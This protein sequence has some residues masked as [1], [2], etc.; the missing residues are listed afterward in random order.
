MDAVW[1]IFGCGFFAVASFF[2]GR[3]LMHPLG[4]IFLKNT[5]AKHP[6]LGI[7]CIF[8]KNGRSRWVDLDFSKE[9][10]DN[11]NNH[12]EVDASMSYRVSPYNVP[13][14]TYMEGLP[15]PIELH[16]VLGTLIDLNKMPPSLDAKRVESHILRVR[17]L[18]RAKLWKE[19]FQ[20]I[21]YTLYATVGT[22]LVS[23]VAVA[24]LF[25]L[26]GEVSEMG[27]KVDGANAVL[28]A[29]NVSLQGG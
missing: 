18:E 7:A 8:M 1:V 22:L 23:V 3:F 12:Y 4:R 26:S 17:A 29:L 20:Y 28:S 14:L 21:K 6:K 11:D 27:L 15:R 16:A 13:M 2:A 5:L 9:G 10:F 24:L 19:E 25:S